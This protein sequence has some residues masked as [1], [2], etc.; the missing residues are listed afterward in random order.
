MSPLRGFLMGGK[1][2]LQRCHPYGVKKK[3]VKY[4]GYKPAPTGYRVSTV[5]ERQ[6]LCTP[7]VLVRG[8]FDKRGRIC[9]L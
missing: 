5:V 2:F 1:F 7:F 4:W 8:L 3:Q 9:Y 6:K